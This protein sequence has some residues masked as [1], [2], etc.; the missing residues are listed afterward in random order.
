MGIWGSS[1]AVCYSVDCGD[2]YENNH[3]CNDVR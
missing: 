3:D 2:G 1:V